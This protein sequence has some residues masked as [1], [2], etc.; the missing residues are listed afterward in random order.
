M[1][2][3]QNSLSVLLGDYD[4]YGDWEIIEDEEEFELDEEEL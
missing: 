2:R 3:S 1:V 4:P